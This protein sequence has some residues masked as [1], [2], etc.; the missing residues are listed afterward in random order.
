M[1]S[2]IHFPC[3][4]L[5]R[6]LSYADQESLRQLRLTCL[7]FAGIGRP[8]AFHTVVIRPNPETYGRLDNILADPGICR[9]VSKIH[10]DIRKWHPYHDVR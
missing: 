6:I 1:T 4:L 7:T 5:D 2:L 10:L 3:E 8:W 9:A